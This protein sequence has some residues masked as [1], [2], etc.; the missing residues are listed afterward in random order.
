MTAAS[1]RDKVA[2]EWTQVG[3]AR[4]RWEGEKRVGGARK[5]RESVTY[6]ETTH[7]AHACESDRPRQ[8]SGWGLYI[9]PPIPPPENPVC[10]PLEI[11]SLDLRLYVFRSGAHY[12]INFS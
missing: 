7:E 8:K 4:E 12:H 9:K 10:G 2:Y 5:R 3:K 1:F 11:S 6:L